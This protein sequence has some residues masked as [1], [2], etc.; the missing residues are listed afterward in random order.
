MEG[1]VSL[2]VLTLAFDTWFLSGIFPGSSAS[3][4]CDFRKLLFNLYRLATSILKDITE[5]E[6]MKK[7]KEFSAISINELC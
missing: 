4:A 5:K 2:W 1:R 7:I 6:M 3:F